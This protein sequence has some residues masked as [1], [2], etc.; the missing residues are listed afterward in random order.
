MAPWQSPLPEEWETVLQGTS[1]GLLRAAKEANGGFIVVVPQADVPGATNDSGHSDA[2]EA[3]RTLDA[4]YTVSLRKKFGCGSKSAV[5][6]LADADRWPN[7]YRDAMKDITAF[8]A[9]LAGEAD[10][11]PPDDAVALFDATA[12]WAEDVGSE[13]LR[14]GPPL[15][16]LL[17][18]Y[19]ED[20]IDRTA[21]SL[22]AKYVA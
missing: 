13:T 7:A 18:A 12:R 1:Q 4:R 11:L 22:V 3:R 9:D 19:V 6:L 2:D 17:V 20:R 10:A 14:N 8:I 15:R 16:S 21:T 5:F